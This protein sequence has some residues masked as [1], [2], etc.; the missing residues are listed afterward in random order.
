[1]YYILKRKRKNCCSVSMKGLVNLVY[2]VFVSC[3]VD[4]INDIFKRCLC[5]CFLL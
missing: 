1:M 3:F 5:N 2:G 4:E